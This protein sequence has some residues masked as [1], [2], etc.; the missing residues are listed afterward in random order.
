[1]LAVVPNHLLDR[2][3]AQLER[4]SGL[5]RGGIK[6]GFIA[7][8]I[9]QA[10]LDRGESS[11]TALL[12]RAEQGDADAALDLR[13]LLTVNYSRFWREPDHWAILAEHLYVRMQ[14]GDLLRMWSAACA[15]GEEAW[16]MALVAAE[17]ESCFGQHSPRWHV[18]GTDID[19]ASLSAAGTARYS[20]E[21]LGNLPERMRR[22]LVPSGTA[23]A[24]RWDV[25]PA[26][27]QHV[28][29]RE[30]DLTRVDWQPPAEAPFEAIFLSNVLIYF[31][32]ETQE[33]ILRH[34]A[35]C[36]RP[37]GI[38]FTSRTEGNLGLATLHLKAAGPCAY[39]TARTTRRP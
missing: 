28:D 19:A 36:L 27:R 20:T 7:S 29:F 21:E 16:T 10:V 1:M 9:A 6:H 22:H 39:I 15:R 37:D 8:R 4:M 33:R 18:L 11:L 31:D 14:S 26:L 12:D 24:P 35:G 38:L 30:L 25:P 23:E 13:N 17:V 34:V 32:L 3:S 5:A 2:T